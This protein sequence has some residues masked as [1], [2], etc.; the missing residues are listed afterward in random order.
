LWQEL[1]GKTINVR[2][3]IIAPAIAARR[4]GYEPDQPRADYRSDLRR[5]GDE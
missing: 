2:Q 4:Q 1:W 5:L 3:E